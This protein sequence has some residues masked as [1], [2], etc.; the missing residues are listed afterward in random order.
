MTQPL[1]SSGG[2]VPSRE[3]VP[4]GDGGEKGSMCSTGGGAANTDSNRESSVGPDLEK[5]SGPATTTD[6]DK[7]EEKH[8]AAPSMPGADDYDELDGSASSSLHDGATGLGRVASRVLS[9]ATTRSGWNPGPPPDG[10][11]RAWLAGGFGAC[12]L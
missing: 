4:A 9:R 11:A 1:A 12:S 10:G 3:P 8:G 5:Q 2:D 6:G 7:Q